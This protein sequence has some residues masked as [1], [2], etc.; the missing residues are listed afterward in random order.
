MTNWQN[1]ANIRDKSMF[2][3]VKWFKDNYPNEKIIIW[4]QNSHI[5]NAP[6]PRYTVNFMDHYLKST[7]G[8]KYYSMGAIVYSGKNLNYND[9]FDFEHN[10]PSYLAY[11]LNKF[12]KNEFILE[13][14]SH[15][16]IDFTNQELLGMESNGNTAGFIA[17]D[18]FD[19]LLFIKH[20][21]IP[22]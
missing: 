20:S 2:D 14:K 4:A 12:Q 21:D 11:H 13:L 9:T 1:N 22:K 3:T 19:G 6:K 7:Y 5:E 15:N 17:K 16:K 18:R 8:D 10:D